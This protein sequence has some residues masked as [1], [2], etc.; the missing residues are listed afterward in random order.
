MNLSIL[1]VNWNT[2]DLLL[3]CLDSILRFAPSVDFEVIV[4]DNASSDGSFVALEQ[5][6]SQC[7][8]LK[9]F[10]SPVN[11][12]F[13]KGVNKA[14]ES[15][16][17]TL[18]LLLNPDTEILSGSLQSL[19]DFMSAT[20]SA[21]VVGPMLIN[22][23]GTLQKSVRNF[24][25]IWSSLL[26]F[27]GLHR[28]WRPVKYFRDD[29]NYQQS[30]MVDQVM[31]AA[32]MTRRRVIDE[33]GFLDENFWLWYEEVDF[34]LRVRQSGYQ[35][36]YTSKAKIKHAQAK[37]FSK[38]GVWQRKWIVTQ[39][40]IYYFKKNG[41]FFDRVLIYIILPFTLGMAGVIGMISY[42]T[43]K[44]TTPHV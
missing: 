12:G 3:N 7:R 18:I 41:S 4:W 15:A 28:F 2:R 44:R 21:G 42:L 22:T 14:Y 24:P 20:P 6:F 36:W 38:L 34:C 26:V 37:A 35:I 11:L 30:A 43:G 25:D 23:D 39:S 5:Q 32:L 9:L 1:I 29:F 13:A 17:G 10:R 40:L 16:K 33:I 19:V 27:T 31:G 8:E